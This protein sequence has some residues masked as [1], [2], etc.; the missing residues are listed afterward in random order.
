MPRGV[1][2]FRKGFILL[3]VLE[4]VL[5]LLV[6][7]FM[8]RPMDQAAKFGAV[9]IFLVIAVFEGFLFLREELNLMLKEFPLLAR[10]RTRQF[11]FRSRTVIPIILL[12]MLVIAPILIT[13]HV[14]TPSE[15]KKTI[16]P[17]V[18]GEE[19][20]YVM[21][22]PSFKQEVTVDLESNDEF[23][24]YVIPYDEEEN[25]IIPSGIPA[26]F[27]G[28][29]SEAP[30]EVASIEVGNITETWRFN[31][32]GERRV[33][34][35]IV[36]DATYTFFV[37]RA[38]SLGLSS[39]PN[40]WENCTFVW[41]HMKDLTTSITLAQGGYRVLLFG[42][43]TDA[44]TEIVIYRWA[45]PDPLAFG[46][47]SDIHIDADLH[48]GR[49][50]IVIFGLGADSSQVQ[51]QST[52]FYLK[53]LGTLLFLISAISL[54]G[55]VFLYIYARSVSEGFVEHTT[56][57]PDI[58]KRGDTEK[59]V[60]DH[61]QK[62]DKKEFMRYLA[63]EARKL[64]ETGNDLFK[65]DHFEDALA[66]FER[67]LAIDPDN[68]S[69]WN[70]KA[71]A[72]R[73]LNRFEEAINSYDKALSLDP[74]NDKF[75]AG[76]DSCLA[77]VSPPDPSEEDILSVEIEVAEEVGE[78]AEEEE[79]AVVVDSTILGVPAEPPSHRVKGERPAPKVLKRKVRP[80]KLPKVKVAEPVE[81]SPPFRK[82][83]REAEA[84]PKEE[85]APIVA[86]VPDEMP[87]HTG[88]KIA[89]T[90]LLAGN[91]IEAIRQYEKLLESDRSDPAIWNNLGFAYRQ[92]NDHDNS[93][94][95]YLEALALNP[96]DRKATNGLKKI[97]R[98]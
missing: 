40:F 10:I 97:G 38:G 2:S 32:E 64:K 79:E 71:I 93:E 24:L 49:Y 3:L 72:L 70:N 9:A 78:K 92:L 33:D 5:L 25:I 66:M 88:R 39:D 4:T 20:F 35:C 45:G 47:G 58:G 81:I 77:E 42:S 60:R 96:G 98:A 61:L 74:K 37:N 11:I 82:P 28:F 87:M 55:Y 76:R 13:M 6:L 80:K 23:D 75:R 43:S 62:I 65:Q 41:P 56:Y 1:R 15:Y 68:A 86:Q 44:H 31:L 91:Y 16:T 48:S 19:S 30:E 90:K 18:P 67:A 36:D 46:S 53:P 63:E 8:M 54:V 14:S 69:I 83:K 51:I 94:R 29:A 95:C 7:E 12:F 50:S 26:T 73:S 57:M 85:P 59:V 27:E 52:V 84:P 89:D 21:G 34:L 22:L 17:A